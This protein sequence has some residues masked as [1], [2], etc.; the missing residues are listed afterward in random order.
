MCWY[1]VLGGQKYTKLVLG[2]FNVHLRWW[3]VFWDQHQ[4][5][6]WSECARCTLWSGWAMRVSSHLPKQMN[7]SVPKRASLFSTSAV[8]PL[9]CQISLSPVTNS[10]GTQSRLVPQTPGKA[11]H[12]PD[13]PRMLVLVLLSAFEELSEVGQSPLG[14]GW[15]QGRRNRHHSSACPQSCSIS[16]CRKGFL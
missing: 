6:R 4:W 15:K 1:F 13:L 16:F 12:H 2:Y 8:F 11:G 9:S 3:D 7:G 5:G 10:I 14:L